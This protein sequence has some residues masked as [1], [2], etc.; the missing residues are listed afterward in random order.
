MDAMTNNRD[1]RE[2]GPGG[3]RDAGL[4]RPSVLAWLRL[5][6]VYQKLHQAEGDH[7]RAY[8]LS[9][10]QFDVLAQVGA[11]EGLMQKDLAAHLLVTKGN[12]SQLLDRMEQHGWIRRCAEGRTQRVW[13]T[14]EGRALRERVVP[15]HEDDIAGH[16][17]A[18]DPTEQRALHRLLRTLDRALDGGDTPTARKEHEN[19]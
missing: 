12:I 18:L 3:A 9:P 14:E 2:V 1:G 15:A 8:N 13:L 19:A 10:A 17:A 16:V 7:L 6:R 5:A 4:R 11:A